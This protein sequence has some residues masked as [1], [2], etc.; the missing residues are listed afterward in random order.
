MEIIILKIVACVCVAIVA[1]IMAWKDNA[2]FAGI[3]LIIGLF[4]ISAM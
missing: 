3:I 2:D 1:G 4:V